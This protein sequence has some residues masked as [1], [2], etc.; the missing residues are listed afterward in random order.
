MS[1][2]DSHHD[3]PGRQFVREAKVSDAEFIASLQAAS[4]TELFDDLSLDTPVAAQ[5]LIEN[6]REAVGQQSGGR[7]VLIAEDQGVSV[8][9]AAMNEGE[10]LALE[11]DASARC[12]GH[13][14][15]LLAAL[16]D[17]A[18]V[19]ELSMWLLPEQSGLIGLIQSAGFGP[20]GK[21]RTLES[22]GAPL[23]Q[24]LWHATL[25]N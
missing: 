12:Q 18:D 22:P 5:D 24:H 7:V 1:E 8:G 2:I 6:W 19:P 21:R 9:F 14:S 25:D 17:L 20:A 11:V 10:I 3:G 15:R 16:A 4:L 13:G 23:V